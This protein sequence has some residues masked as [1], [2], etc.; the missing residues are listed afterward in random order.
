M[1]VKRLK[2]GVEGIDAL[3]EGGVPEGSIV[4]VAGTPGTGKTILGLQFLVE[5]AKAKEMGILISFEQE[6][7]DIITQAARFG[8]DIEALEKKNL[9]RLVCMWPSS[10]DEVMT[11]IFKCLY[12]KPKR[13]VV[14]SVTSI[15][16]S[17]QENREAFHKMTEKLK[18]SGLTAILTSEL[19]AR[20]KG[21]SRDGVSEFVSDGLV[22]LNS[23]EVA[24]EHKN[25][26]RVEKLR[27]T[28]IN[29][30]SHLYDITDKGFQLTAPPGITKK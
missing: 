9:I 3:I 22:I 25:L 1:A 2:S 21:Y 19:L 13:L 16:Y 20:Q 28:K 18:K 8:W 14:D 26:M 4:L 7:K 10:F 6:R 11:K 12:Y 17:M 24:G 15:T 29:K 27:S 23:L 30:E 5:G